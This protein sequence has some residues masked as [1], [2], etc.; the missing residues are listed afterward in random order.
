MI[1]LYNFT[2]LKTS[3][4]IKKKV[5][6][7]NINFLYIL[8]LRLKRKYTFTSFKYTLHLIRVCYSLK[9]TWYPQEKY[10]NAKNVLVIYLFSS[11]WNIFRVDDSAGIRRSTFSVVCL[12]AQTSFNLIRAVTLER[13]R[14]NISRSVCRRVI[15]R[16]TRLFRTI[17][18]D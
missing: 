14:N 3:T 8:F 15:L 12:R 11:S 18:S 5:I 17:I 1:I 7:I 9:L 13:E 2:F 4:K 16:E 6:K 10:R